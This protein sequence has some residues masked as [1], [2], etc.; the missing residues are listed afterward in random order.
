MTRAIEGSFHDP[1]LHF[2]IS[3]FKDFTFALNSCHWIYLCICSHFFALVRGEK[4]FRRNYH[5]MIRLQFVFLEAGL[6]SKYVFTPHCRY[7]VHFGQIICVRNQ[8]LFFCCCVSVK[9]IKAKFDEFFEC[10]QQIINQPR[11]IILWWAY[12]R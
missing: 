12:P 3:S 8:D 9:I 7:N 6:E 10:L 1:I 2:F 5:T 11:T 4:I